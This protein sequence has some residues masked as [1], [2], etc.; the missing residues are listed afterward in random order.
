MNS[1]YNTLNISICFPK[2]QLGGNIPSLAQLGF[3]VTDKTVDRC[4]LSN[5][6]I[7]QSD[8]FLLSFCTKNVS[9]VVSKLIV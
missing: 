4:T 7:V 5:I 2:L 6:G 8:L 3:I 1:P 9:F